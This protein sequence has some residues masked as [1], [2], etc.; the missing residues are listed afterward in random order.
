MKD[1]TPSVRK[2]AFTCPHCHVFAHQYW[3]S[4]R[5]KRL[6]GG[7]LP[8]DRAKIDFDR[9]QGEDPYEQ[10]TRLSHFHE[11]P[12]QKNSRLSHADLDRLLDAGTPLLWR[13]SAATPSFYP[14]L[15]NVF[16]SKCS[17]CE[18]LAI[19]IYDQLAH[20]RTGGAPPAHSDLP[21]DIRRDYD[22]A[23]S[24]LDLSPRGAAALVRLSIEKLCRQLSE[25]L[26]QP[27]NNLN[28]NIA[29]LV[30]NGL[31]PRIQKALDAVRIYGNNAVHPGV[32]DLRAD[33]ETAEKLFKLLNLIVERMIS[34][35]KHID[36]VY[37]ALPEKQRKSVEKRDS[38]K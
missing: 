34:I 5:A 3:Y 24:I 38:K 25:E 13:A 7:K 21:D 30:K 37:E 33:R 31:D 17:H 27:G 19:W 16:L 1:V 35:P 32:I 28:A 18:Q 15:H 29:M 10:G 6:K 9:T 2:L 22:E 26:G 23:S 8:L 20:P 12:T 11:D 36:E 14:D 4:L